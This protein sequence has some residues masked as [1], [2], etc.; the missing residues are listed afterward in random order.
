MMSSPCFPSPPSPLSSTRPP[1]PT[2]SAPPCLCLPVTHQPLLQHHIISL[3]LPHL[4]QALQQEALGQGT[5]RAQGGGFLHCPE[6]TV[7]EQQLQGWEQ[8][9]A[10]EICCPLP[11]GSLS[12]GLRTPSLLATPA[13]LPCPDRRL[14]PHPRAGSGHLPISFM[15]LW[16]VGSPEGLGGSAGSGL[17]QGPALE[18]L[19][20]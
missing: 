4:L 13:S 2:A 11:A 15:G 9:V 18:G 8:M 12:G 1:H 7:P 10:Q 14:P 20:K 6:C 3:D 19:Y 16:A 17:C 5:G